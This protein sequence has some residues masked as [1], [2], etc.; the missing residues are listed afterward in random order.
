MN[1]G[2][3][4]STSQALHF[5]YMIQAYEVS[6]ESIM[7]K[8]IRAIMKDLG[9]WDDGKPS[10]VDFGSLNALEVRAQCAMIRAMV[11]DRLPGPEAWAIQA[12]YGFNEIALIDGKKRLVFS[13][14]RYEAIM[15]LGDWMVPSF[16]NFNPLA[17]DLLI[18]RA[19]DKRVTDVT[20]R[21]I[22]EQFGLTHSTYH[23]ALK[24]VRERVLEL[25][26]RA[27]DRLA[28]EFVRDGLSQ[29]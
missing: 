5:A 27:I 10:T 28:P 26:N 19:V 13:R 17:V 3:F 20:F 8:A 1:Q 23:Y 11:R 14:E 25:E 24:R 9:I 21:Q 12:R 15:N 2:I 22:A 18:A 16:P 6:V 4:R 29:L 7:S